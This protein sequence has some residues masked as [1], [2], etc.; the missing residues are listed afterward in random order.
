MGGEG[1]LFLKEEIQLL[2]VEEKKQIEKSTL[3]KHHG[4]K[5]CR[6]DPKMKAKTGQ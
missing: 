5:C 1:P 3:G 6:Q 4:T 2:K